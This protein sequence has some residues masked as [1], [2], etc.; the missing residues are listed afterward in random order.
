MSLR[1]W[2]RRHAVQCFSALSINGCRAWRRPLRRWTIGHASAV[3]AIAIGI[4]VVAADFIEYTPLL[5]DRHM[6]TGV[7]IGR[8]T[9]SLLAG[10]AAKR[11]GI[12]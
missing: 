11:Q 4:D 7:L 2:R 6:T 3:R 8:L 5:D 12:T 9:Q 10:S 1:D